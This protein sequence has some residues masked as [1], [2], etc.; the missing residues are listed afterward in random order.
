[1]IT[2]ISDMK[3]IIKFYL[4]SQHT[5]VVPTDMEVEILRSVEYWKWKN[6]GL[7]SDLQTEIV[8]SK[9][10]GPDVIP[11]GSV[12]FCKDYTL[13]IDQ[14]KGNAIFKPLGI[15]DCMKESKYLGRIYQY[16]SPNSDFLC[17][18]GSWFVKSRNICKF[19]GNGWYNRGDSLPVVPG[20]VDLTSRLNDIVGEFRV[21]LGR[22]GEI[23]DV[24]NY[25]GWEVW[26]NKNTL[27]RFAELLYN[28]I[29][30]PLSF[31]VVVTSSGNTYFLE[32][33]D[34]WALGLYG[35]SEP[36]S[37]PFYIKDWWSQKI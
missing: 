16:H 29:Q 27:L 3:T 6:L 2:L 17:P 30:R 9:D 20:G 8:I 26:P 5:N 28:E 32:A 24:R 1:M 37:L 13:K 33:H 34:Y 18:E 12:E 25:I 14:L 19:V 11:L 7:D 4:Q 35:F 22:R 23:K 31:D 15:P 10:P 36:Q 21:F